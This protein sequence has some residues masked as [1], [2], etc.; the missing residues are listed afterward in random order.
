MVVDNGGVIHFGD[1]L[2]GISKYT[3]TTTSVDSDNRFEV[4]SKTDI[5]DFDSCDFIFENNLCR[6]RVKFRANTKIVSPIFSLSVLDDSGVDLFGDDNSSKDEVVLIPGNYIFEYSFVNQLLPGKYHF[7][8]KWRSSNSAVILH[9][10]C[11]YFGIPTSTDT[12]L[13]KYG[14]VSMDTNWDVHSV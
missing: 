12:I 6:L 8:L 14:R 4:L 5:I 10:Y 3:E 7:E 11:G 13:R 2:K 9:C 1:T